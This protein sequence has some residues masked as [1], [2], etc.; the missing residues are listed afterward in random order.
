MY[1]FKIEFSGGGISKA[2]LALCVGFQYIHTHAHL[3]IESEI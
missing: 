2:S 3:W 1:L